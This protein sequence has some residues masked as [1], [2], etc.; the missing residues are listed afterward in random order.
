MILFDCC[1]K[2]H[3]KEVSMD[4]LTELFCEIDDFCEVFLNELQKYLLTDGNKKRKRNT[5]ISIAEIITIYIL[6]HQVRYRDFKRFYLYYIK[7]ICARDF[8]NMPSY[9]RFV[10]LY[11]RAILP[12]FAYL[13]SQFPPCDGISFVDSTSLAVCDNHRISK[14][15]TFSE[16]AKRGKTSMGW[17]FGFKLHLVINHKGEILGFYMS[18]GNLDDRKGLIKLSQLFPLTGLVIGDKGYLSKELRDSL[19]KQGIRL[20]TKVRKNMNPIEKTDFEKALLKKRGIV[21]TVIDEL[22]NLCQIEHT[23]HRSE[24]GFMMN[25]LAGV[26]AYC[27]MPKKPSIKLRQDHLIELMA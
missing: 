1:K 8:P 24:Y 2:E 25:L 15:K 21:E 14:H 11:P 7:T 27:R 19:E 9:S 3:M 4:N 17:F 22:K 12:M 16:T 6:F 23:R 10:E 26:A 20:I 5:G 13:Q 18:G